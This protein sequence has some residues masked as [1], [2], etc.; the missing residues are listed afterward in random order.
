[1][2]EI[3]PGTLLRIFVGESDRHEGKPMYEAIVN[4]ARELNLAG[5]TTGSNRQFRKGPGLHNSESNV[6][7]LSEGV[8]LL[9]VSTERGVSVQ[10]FIITR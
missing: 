3:R 9:K 7:A 5:A 4:K 10:K 8:Y 1:M 6:S 2:T